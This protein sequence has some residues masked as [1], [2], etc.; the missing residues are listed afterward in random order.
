MK[1][2]NLNTILVSSIIAISIIM[3]VATVP[4]VHAA[5]YSIYASPSNLV[6]SPGKTALVSI[7]ASPGVNVS[8]ARLTII[9]YDSSIATITKVT[10]EL[11]NAFI[12]CKRMILGKELVVRCALASATPCKGE[13]CK[14][15][16]M[17]VKG[18]NA[19]TTR[20]VINGT[21]GLYNGTVYVVPPVTIS[22]TVKSP[23]ISPPPTSPQ[24]KCRVVLIAEHN[25]TYIN[26]RDIISAVLLNCP[27][28]AGVTLK[29]TYNGT[30]INVVNVIPGDFVKIVG[31]MFKNVVTHNEIVIAAA[32]ARACDKSRTVIAKI[33]FEAKKP[34][35]LTMYGQAQIAYSNGNVTYVKVTPIVVRIRKYLECDLNM[36]GR[37]DIGDVVL[38]L[39]AILGKIKPKVP[40]D[41]N[42]NGRIDIGDAYLL[43]MKIMKQLLGT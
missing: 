21:V 34:G 31:G 11:P 14:I 10:P 22:V 23:I 7:Y 25:V 36:N 12:A 41:L 40:C 24:G 30:L 38:L 35:M 29:L 43:L 16:T 4:I 3:I 13:T 27:Q 26:A 5:S 33:I 8:G 28:A 17:T 2:P 19:G 32:G 42:H 37:L 39:K 15:I 1:I 9:V 18:V 6:L 20:I